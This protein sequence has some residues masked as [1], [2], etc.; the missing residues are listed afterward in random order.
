[1]HHIHA[2]D[3]QMEQKDETKALKMIVLNNL[4][5]MHEQLA[6]AIALVNSAFTFQVKFFHTF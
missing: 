5:K 3:L 6:D 4:I 2:D 1:M